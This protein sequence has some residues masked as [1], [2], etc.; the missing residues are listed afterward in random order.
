M[1]G[2]VSSS[3]GNDTYTLTY[4]PS[5]DQPITV[6]SI[7]GT[8][9]GT[10]GTADAIVNAV[11]SITS[12]GVLSGT[13]S[14][15]SLA[16]TVTPRGSVAVFDLLIATQGDACTFGG[17]IQHSGLVA[18]DSSAKRIFIL[19]PNPGRNNAVMFVGIKS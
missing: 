4:N 14:N 11:V 6:A 19:A 3:L 9:S 16:G 15:C 12:S 1:T 5:Y 13:F 2:S 18:Y 17:K 8:Y 7:V 10:L